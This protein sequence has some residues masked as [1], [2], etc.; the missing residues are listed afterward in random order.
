MVKALD[1]VVIDRAVVRAWWL[2][3]VTRVIVTDR[4]TLAIHAQVFGTAGTTCVCM[5]RCMWVGVQHSTAC[6]CCYYCSAC[7][8]IAGTMLCRSSM[9]MG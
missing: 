7:H 6:C 3:K 2:V 4:N 1:A 9:Q 5:C 8:H